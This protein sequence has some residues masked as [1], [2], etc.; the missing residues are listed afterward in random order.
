MRITLKQVAEEAG[1]SFSLVSKYLNKNPSARMSKRTMERIDG[2]V[3]RLHYVP[4]QAARS[5][6]NGKTKNIGLVISNLRNTYFSLLADYTLREVKRHGYQLVL[7]LCDYGAKEEEESLRNLVNM[8]CDGIIYMQSITDNPLLARLAKEHYPLVLGELSHRFSTISADFTRSFQRMVNEI[9]KRGHRSLLLVHYDHRRPNDAEKKC[10]FPN[11][12]CETKLVSTMNLTEREKQLREICGTRPPLLFF[13]GWKTA[14]LFLEMVDREFP[15]YE[16]EIIVNSFF[17]FPILSDPRVIGIVRHDMRK[18]AE[19][20]VRL[21]I[22]RINGAPVTAKEM[23][24]DYLSAEE[25]RSDPAV[26]G[27]EHDFAF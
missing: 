21:L 4:S 14:T 8:Q 7:S 9:G 13:Y 15:G 1:V 18:S 10:L 26:F 12:N 2:A 17:R 27:E 24:P 11:L 16:P 19:E 3:S 25:F 6:K 20:R 5:L 23:V 22:D